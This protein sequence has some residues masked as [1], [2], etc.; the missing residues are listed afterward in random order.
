MET[1]IIAITAI[2]LVFVF[3]ILAGLVSISN[4]LE[5]MIKHQ[6]EIIKVLKNSNK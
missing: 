4:M 3:F 2:M 1:I 6:N 5:T